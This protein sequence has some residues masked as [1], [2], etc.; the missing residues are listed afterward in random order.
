MGRI[1]RLRGREILDSRGTPTLEAEIELDNGLS[2]RAAVPSGAST[3]QSEAVELRDG[4][5]GRFGG[6]GVQKAVH[7]IETEI[8]PLLTGRDP[9]EQATLDGELIALDGTPDKSRLGANAILAVS[10]AL[11]RAGAALCHQPLFRYLGGVDARV[12]PIPMMNV[13]NGGA[14][15]Q[16]SLDFQ[17][18]MIMPIGARSLAEALRWGSEIFHA[19]RGELLLRH[20]PTAVGDEGGFAPDLGSPEEAIEPILDAV[21]AA[22]RQP[23]AEVAIAIDA[24][25]SELFDGGRYHFRRAQKPPLDAEA[26]IDAFSD[27]LTRYPIASIEDPLSE[28][29]WPA[30]KALTRRLGDRAQIVGDDL[31][32]TNVRRLSRGID[33]GA[34]N[35][36]LIKPNQ[37]GTITETMEAIHLSRAAGYRHVI[38]HRSGE[39]EDEF[40]ADLCVTT[41]AG[42]I[43]CGAPSR[44]ERLAKYN[45]LLRI[46]EALGPS[47]RFDVLRPPWKALER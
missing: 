17:E 5:M 27:W 36:I 6:K 32:T 21:R 30:W 4:D 24:A 35:A 43:K 41:G 44:S 13:L 40:I 1:A 34:A 2:V 3:G 46:E 23:G 38:S 26:M 10:M 15:A 18:F 29:D 14:H 33:E 7:N 11:A 28:N 22:G 9:R 19:L 31:F 37:I 42:Q 47:A 39:T 16:N 45:R 8:A 12:M 25:A 20:K